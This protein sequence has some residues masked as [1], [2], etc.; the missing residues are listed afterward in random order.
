MGVPQESRETNGIHMWSVEWE[1]FIAGED[2]E[3]MVHFLHISSSQHWRRSARDRIRRKQVWFRDAFSSRSTLWSFI[4]TPPVGRDHI[5]T[6]VTACLIEDGVAEIV[7]HSVDWKSA[8]S[9]RGAA[10]LD[11]ITE[12]VPPV[13]QIA[14]LLWIRVI[15][16][17]SSYCSR[18]WSR[19]GR[20]S[21]WAIFMP[22]SPILRI[23]APKFAHY[24]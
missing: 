6:L 16:K 1:S 21:N 7:L 19:G 15:S 11:E 4:A 24:K 14:F 9:V 5:Q 8:V 12:S 3:N 22:T 20:M 10:L 13:L 17:E 2:G 18:S 23:M